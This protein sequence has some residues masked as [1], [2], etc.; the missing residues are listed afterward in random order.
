VV[1]TGEQGGKA[2]TVGLNLTVRAPNQVYI[3]GRGLDA[4]LGGQLSLRGTTAD[5]IPV[6]QFTLVRG[7]LSILGKRI[8]LD[9]GELAVSGDIDPTFRLVG[10][11]STDDLTIQIITQG[12]IS[13]PELT[14]TSSPE[15]PDEEIL[16][17]LLFGRALTEISALQAAQMAAAVATL[18]GGGGDL[19]GSIRK[20]FGLDDI[21]LTTSENGDAALKVGKYLSEKIYTDVTI[22]SSGK[23]EINLNLDASK[24][25]TVKGSLSTDGNTSLGVFFEKDY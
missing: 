23:S 10:A 15:L 6:G 16:S 18:T 1:N 7:R 14:L 20:S 13:A 24:N 21:D 12:R 4:E 11:T 9:E 8:D 2:S 22:D 25:V 5:I 3:R 19:S 17:Q